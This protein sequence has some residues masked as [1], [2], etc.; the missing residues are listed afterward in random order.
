MKQN[1]MQNLVDSL[2]NQRKR[3]LHAIETVTM[4]DLKNLVSI[5]QVLYLIR[6]KRIMFLD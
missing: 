2:A 6:E 3:H 4:T 1:E 5:S